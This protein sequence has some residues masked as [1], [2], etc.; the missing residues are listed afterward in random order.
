M[1]LVG[2]SLG[3]DQ[4][5]GIV[6][7]IDFSFS[8]FRS[9]EGAQAFSMRREPRFRDVPSDE[10]SRAAA[11]YGANASGKSNFL[12]ALKAMRDLVTTS[13]SGGSATSGIRRQPFRLREGSE[14]EPSSFLM[15]CIADDGQRYRYSFSYDDA[16]VLEEE[17]V[18]YR[19]IDGR[20]STHSSALFSRDESGAIEFGPSFK[21]PRAQVRKTMDL[22][23]NALLLSA[24]AAAGIRCV[25]P[26]FRFFSDEMAYC[27]AASFL[28]EQP[29]VHEQY[30]KGTSFS[31]KLTA[32]VRYADFGITDIEAV[33][34]DISREMPDSLPMQAGK[35]SG[36]Y[37]ASS[38]ATALKFTHAGTSVSAVF[39][40]GDESRGTIA[41]MSFF[42]LALRQLGKRSVTMIDEIDTSLHPGLVREFVELYADPATNPHGAQLIFTTHDVT[43]IDRTGPVSPLSADQ[44]WLVEKGSLGASELFPVTDVGIRK[45][46]N[47]GR[48]YLNGVYGAAPQPSFHAAFARMVSEEASGD[49]HDAAGE[50]AEGEGE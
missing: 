46:E 42:S 44:V 3:G 43:L 11:I 18:F 1:T 33:P 13:Y 31:K 26:V 21:G 36:E 7:L 49:A 10:L 14:S 37:A 4:K 47:I 48:N 45:D 30:G 50:W 20:P 9:F 27:D 16:R 28:G 40:L 12:L 5:G 34:V 25:Q 35:R 22:R 41:A 17:L 38:T 15:E 23:P 2:G 32:L 6:M 8:N 29:F 19:L 24:A 39:G